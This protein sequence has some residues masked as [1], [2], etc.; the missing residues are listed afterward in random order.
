MTVL[1]LGITG[2]Y[3]TE[4]Q[5]RVELLVIHVLDDAPATGVLQVDDIIIGANGRLFEDTED[6]RPEMG[7]ALVE[8]Q[9]P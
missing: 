8:S 2:A 6:P 7:H 3:V 4:A 5:N 1:P 9:S